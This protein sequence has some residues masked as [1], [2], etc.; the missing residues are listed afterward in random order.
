MIDRY[1]RLPKERL[2]APVAKRLD[3]PP[4]A[5]TF[6]AFGVGLL[7]VGTAALGFYGWALALWLIGRVLD[8]L[9]GSIARSSAKQSDLGG[10]LDILLDTVIYTLLPVALAWTQASP[11]VWLSVALL[12]SSF[13]LNAGSWMYLSAILEKRKQGAHAQGEQTSVT[14]PSG[15]IEGGETILF[16]C[17]FLIFPNAL[18]FLFSLMALLVL[19]TTVQR[20]AWAAR[21]LRER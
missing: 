9:D 19:V 3:I 1:L 11:F 14:M 10:Y 8:G 6:T 15:L 20:V 2:L 18:T 12:L 5:V 4:L 13:Y 17:L 7:A 16:Y 21:H